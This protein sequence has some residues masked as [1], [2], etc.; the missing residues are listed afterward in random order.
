M[1]FT[2]PSLGLVMMVPKVGGDPV[3]LAS[4]GETRGVAT[5][6]TNVYYTVRSGSVMKAP[7]GGGMSLP[8]ATGQS[9]PWS[10]TVDATS[11]YWTNADGNTI[12]KLT[13]K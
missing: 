6:G 4:P 7:A 9:A 5:D 3:P 12:M 10:I 2:D 1:Y 8:I 11:V 13:P